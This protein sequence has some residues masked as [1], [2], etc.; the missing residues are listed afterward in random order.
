M[1]SASLSFAFWSFPPAS[2]WGRES[3]IW[4]LSL[5]HETSAPLIE[6]AGFNWSRRLTHY[7]RQ[8][9]WTGIGEI[10]NVLVPSDAAVE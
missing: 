1:S 9:L 5:F 3:C 4:Q 7:R 6:L 10:R 8:M 2:T